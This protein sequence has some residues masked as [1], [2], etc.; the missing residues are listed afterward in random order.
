M[1]II[2]NDPF[3]RSAIFGT[4]RSDHILGNGNADRIFG[5]RG[6]D[7]IDGGVVRGDHKVYIDGGTGNDT[8]VVRGDTTLTGSAGRNTFILDRPIAREDMATIFLDPERDVFVFDHSNNVAATRDGFGVL[9]IQVIGLETIGT[10]RW[11]IVGEVT[12]RSFGED[13][14]AY[15][16]LDFTDDG[17][18][19][20]NEL[21]VR[22][23]GADPYSAIDAFFHAQ[24][25]GGFAPEDTFLV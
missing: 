23:S 14:E 6:N 17:K 21:R 4:A 11:A 5:M 2:D 19:V 1:P 13:G 15:T 10:Q 16:K 3:D 9:D 7:Y 18:G 25:R 12:I 20:H 8:L 24:V 22:Y